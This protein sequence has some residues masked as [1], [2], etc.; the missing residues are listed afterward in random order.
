MAEQDFSKVVQQLQLA[1]EK[2]ARLER[3]QKEGGTAKGIIAASLPE[4]LNERSLSKRKEQF[5][6]KT[7]IT[8]TDD[9]VRDNTEAI[10]NEV[11]DLKKTTEKT[12]KAVKQTAKVSLQSQVKKDLMQADL[13]QKGNTQA[14]KDAINQEVIRREELEKKREELKQKKDEARQAQSMFG[15]DERRQAREE[16]EQKELNQAITKLLIAN[17]LL[18]SAKKKELE[19]DSK[20][21]QADI[22]SEGLSKIIAPFK[23]TQNFLKNLGAKPTGIPGLNLGRL[24]MLV[25]I[26]MLIKFLNSPQFDEVIKIITGNGAVLDDLKFFFTQLYN[27]LAFLGGGILDI[28]RFFSGFGEK[29]F[30]EQ[31]IFLK[32]NFLEMLLAIGFLASGLNPFRLLKGVMY[33]GMALLLPTGK[34]GVLTLLKRA[35]IA[36]ATVIGG[37]ATSMFGLTTIGTGAATA[38]ALP[39]IESLLQCPSG[40]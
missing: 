28:L 15:K 11:K 40:W 24:A 33:A 14:E 35:F 18:D 19:K 17:P 9:A 36:I 8:Q 34:F 27:G 20:K 10:A 37:L 26:P 13:I 23:A 21:I 30:T 6:T 29:T 5:D 38:A 31:M 12:T 4:V 3:L 39:Q 2:L 32:D 25:A 16:K 1:N 7:G 22:L